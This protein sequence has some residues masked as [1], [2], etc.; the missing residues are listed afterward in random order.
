MARKH[1]I[2]TNKQGEQFVLQSFV[3]GGNY[4]IPYDGSKYWEHHFV[5]K[6]TWIPLSV[7]NFDNFDISKAEY[8]QFKAM[9]EQ[10][11]KQALDKFHASF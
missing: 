5:P 9:C 11:Q 7:V 1:K 4:L 8:E 2:V 6:H 10:G 3:V